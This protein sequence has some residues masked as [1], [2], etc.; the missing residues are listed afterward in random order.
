MTEN[1]YEAVM[2]SPG[3]ENPFKT[4]PVLRN[5]QRPKLDRKQRKIRDAQLKQFGAAK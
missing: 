1:T 5:I 4:E 3:E 2:V